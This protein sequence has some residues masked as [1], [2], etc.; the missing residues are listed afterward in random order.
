MRARSAQGTLEFDF[1]CDPESIFKQ[2]RKKKRMENQAQHDD[3]VARMRADMARMQLEMENR[4][5]K[6]RREREQRLR[7]EAQLNTQPRNA[8]QYMHPEL[9][10]PEPA[11]VLPEVSKNFEI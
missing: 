1:V 4:D 11:I 8:R 9:K 2:A 5:A 3:D 7:L 6:M 10:V